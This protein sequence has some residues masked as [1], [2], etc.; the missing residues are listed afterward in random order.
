M[1]KALWNKLFPAK[2]ETALA[3]TD[4]TTVVET[5]AK[6][7]EVTT[8]ADGIGHETVAVETVVAP[9]PKKPRAKKPA[10]QTAESSKK[11]A[12]PKKPKTTKKA[13]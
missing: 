8:K 5:P 6:V 11:P 1:I 12:T 7:E 13:K 2:A 3:Y 4:R 10:A 9:A